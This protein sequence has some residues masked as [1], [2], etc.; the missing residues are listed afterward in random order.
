MSEWAKAKPAQSCHK[1]R[2]PLNQVV[3]FWPLLN[4][5][6]KVTSQFTFW[7]ISLMDPWNERCLGEGD[8]A[9]VASLFDWDFH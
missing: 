6:N 1:K 4:T 7:L 3:K 2:I 9:W 8:Y 5:V